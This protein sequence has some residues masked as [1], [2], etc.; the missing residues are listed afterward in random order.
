MR[1]ASCAGKQG[2][3]RGGSTVGAEAVQLG[4][5]V[6]LGDHSTVENVEDTITGNEAEQLGKKQCS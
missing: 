5:A 3:W 4:V 6:Q 2:N 1:G